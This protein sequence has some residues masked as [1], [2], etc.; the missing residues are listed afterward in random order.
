MSLDVLDYKKLK[1]IIHRKNETFSLR[2]E[3]CN[4]REKSG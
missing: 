3:E 2:V 4:T 1:I